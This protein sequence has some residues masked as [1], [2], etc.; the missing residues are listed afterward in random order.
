MNPGEYRQMYEVEESH[1][2]YVSLHELIL[3]VVRGVKKPAKEL[4]IL[5]AGCGTGRL[6]MLLEGFGTVSGCDI[7]SEA[8]ELCRTRGL[9]SVFQAD[10]NS[11]SFRSSH[12][13]VITSIDTL[14]HLGIDDELAVL[15]KFH[16]ALKPGGFLILNLVAHEFLRSTHD[17]AVHTRKRYS[18]K[19]VETLLEKSG[20]KVMISSYRLGFLFP[21]IAALRFMKRLLNFCSDPKS[22][23][24]DVTSPNRTLNR[25]LLWAA[26]HENRFV[27]KSAVPLGTSVFAVAQ[28]PLDS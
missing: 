17:I 21:P 11:V 24:S 18:R 2:W 23:K 19:E 4:R 14:Y 3:S 26:R 7:S 16:G 8:L 22:V 20:F 13:D 9:K 10:L 6:C 15:K 28:K 5:D 25:L 1:W 27:L 12:Y